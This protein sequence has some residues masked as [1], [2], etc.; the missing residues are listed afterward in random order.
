MS[1]FF[2]HWASNQTKLVWLS[3]PEPIDECPFCK[4]QTDVVYK[5]YNV[6]YKHYSLFV[7]GKGDFRAS[8]TCRNCT[9]EGSLER[10]Y[11]EYLIG[12]YRFTINC[13]EILKKHESHPYKA[14]QKLQ[15]LVTDAKQAGYE[16]EEQQSILEALE[17]NIT[18]KN[19][20]SQ[21][22]KTMQTS[23][24]NSTKL[25]IKNILGSKPTQVSISSVTEL[26]EKK[27]GDQNRLEFILK[28]LKEGKKLYAS[29]KRY[30]E[31]KLK[32]I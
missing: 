25:K 28:A 29:D 14:V 15:K 32:S 13:E 11:E 3:K 4:E 2:A 5:I 21:I 23:K 6:N 7:I 22:I 27:I 24:D 30:V 1:F 12:N 8:F 26:I 16:Y 19:K 20:I 9:N 17:S 10:K 31:T 18:Q